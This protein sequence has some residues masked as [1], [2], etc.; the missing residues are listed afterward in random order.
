MESSA[1]FRSFWM[2]G[3]E[4]STH[5]NGAGT[6]LDMIAS[7][8]HDLH[9]SEDYTLLAGVGML[10]ARD[11]LRWHR[12]DRCGGMRFDSWL[13][14][15][16]ASLAP[17]VQVIWDLCHYGFPDDV[18]LL[19][20]AFVH[21][22]ERFARAAARMFREH[23]DQVPF[24]APVNEINFFTWGAV[25]P[26]IYPHAA[27]RDAEVKAQLIRG[28]VAAAA[29]VRDVD[30]RARLVY[31]EPVLNAVAPPGRP[32][33]DQA[34]RWEN[35]GQYE[36]WDMIAGFRAPE[37]GGT[38]EYLDILGANFYYRNQWEQHENE[39]VY[40]SWNP[41]DRDPRWIPFGE[42]LKSTY[43]RYQ[44]PIFVAETGHFGR[45]RGP[46]LADIAQEVALC[47]EGGVPVEG[48]CLYPVIDRHDW[49]DP[50]HWHAAGLWDLIPAPDGGLKRIL[51][52]D[53]AAELRRCMDLVEN[54]LT[55]RPAPASEPGSE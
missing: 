4:C 20:P 14:L 24:W 3:F 27:G 35:D 33:L 17:G 40:Y 15:L 25:R 44:R 51:N 2:G 9:A 43:T 13:P 55:G 49:N 45:G 26:L 46:W 16:K 39:R 1:G 37:L 32:D 36:A 41:E 23:S 53:Y 11:G 28:A 50:L 12:I 54:A 38:P 7:T 34:V 29:A 52:E 6:R 21:R 18:D 30:P 48:V 5:I 10:T 47:I 31:P 19:K 42:L 22:L 8:Q